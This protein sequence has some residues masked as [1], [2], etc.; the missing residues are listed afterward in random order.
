MYLFRL[1]VSG[2]PGNL[3]DPSA[4]ALPQICV[5]TGEFPL[6]VSAGTKLVSKPVWLLPRSIVVKSKTK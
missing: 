4:Q 1:D 6:G 2:L 5:Y 3:A